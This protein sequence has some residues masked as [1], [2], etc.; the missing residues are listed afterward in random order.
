LLDFSYKLSPFRAGLLTA[1][2]LATRQPTSL[3]AL[4]LSGGF[5]A[6]PV[7]NPI[8]KLKLSAAALLPGKKLYQEITNC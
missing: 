2:S 6:D 5:A 8:T 3:T 4:I 7:T 1:L